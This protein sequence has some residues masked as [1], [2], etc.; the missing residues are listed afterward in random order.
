M[1][2]TSAPP[3]LTATSQ[4]TT[5]V[6]S[7]HDSDDA[8][9]TVCSDSEAVDIEHDSG[10]D[11][12]SET[13]AV[14]HSEY[15]Q[16]QLR[17]YTPSPAPRNGVT[18]HLDEALYYE[19]KHS[20]VTTVSP[21]SI[22]KQQYRRRAFSTCS[23][24]VALAHD[25]T[26]DMQDD[27][28]G[29]TANNSSNSSTSD[30]QQQQQQRHNGDHDGNES[31]H[32]QDDNCDDDE[33]NCHND[34]HNNDGGN[35]SSDSTSSDDSE[36][37]DDDN[38]DAE[39]DGDSNDSDSDNEEEEKTP[40]GTP[41]SIAYAIWCA[42]QRAIGR[43]PSLLIAV[44]AEELGIDLRA[45]SVNTSSTDD[46]T[47]IA[48]QWTLLK[49]LMAYRN[50]MHK[51]MRDSV[52][53]KLP[54]VNTIEDVVELIQEKSNILIIAGAGL[55]T[56]AGIPDF[57]SE[58]GLY[59]ML[60]QYNLPSPQS[61]FDIAFFKQNPTP[62]FQ[63]AKQLLPGNYTPSD[64]HRFVKLL[65]SK[66]KLL[67]MYTQ[68]I[69]GLEIQAGVTHD[70][71]HQC[72]GS[73]D[74]AKCLYCR[75]SVPLA[76]IEADILAQEIPMCKVCNH[77]EGIIKPDI[78]FFGENLGNKFAEL[79]DVDRQK[80]DLVIVIGS[81]LQVAPVSQIPSW[82][83]KHVPQVLIN[84]EV[85]GQ[86]CKFDCELL[87]NCD[88]VCNT[89]CDKLNASTGDDNSWAIDSISSATTADGTTATLRPDDSQQALS[90]STAAAAAAPTASVPTMMS[91]QQQQL[92][93][94]S[95]NDYLF[96]EPNTYYFRK[97]KLKSKLTAETDGVSSTGLA[98][99]DLDAAVEQ[100]GLQVSDTA[101]LTQEDVSVNNEE[102]NNSTTAAAATTVPVLSPQAAAT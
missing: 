13:S 9:D 11:S 50:T 63:F 47:E 6:R 84:R 40:L 25:D 29:T 52:R 101:A 91:E 74:T 16:E 38:N 20:S 53:P 42:K 69:D 90:E 24:S 31:C 30:S 44:L 60:G 92:Q 19:E 54:S 88:D 86:P 4:Q 82:I 36:H 2:I 62:F 41:F 15:E 46:P 49:K 99:F 93:C 68:N 85:V 77:P 17:L 80:C 59:S 48:I 34:D 10:S 32:D 21:S 65:E 58:N 23:S 67:R 89:L 78:V 22:K 37:D 61:M 33:H 71:V 94:Q 35:D 81:S 95:Y 97:G 7:C 26:H 76:A 12:D 8:S 14:I 5:A 66:G 1:Y 64:T 102:D 55:S 56:S 83:P 96:E 3:L 98:L 27:D 39:Q 45:I 79:L 70:R 18:L 72:H 75:T 51:R 43:S 73:L 87:G 28:D 100:Y 57:R